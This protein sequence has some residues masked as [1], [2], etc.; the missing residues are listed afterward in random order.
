M[1]NFFLFHLVVIFLVFLSIRFWETKAS[2]LFDI[3]AAVGEGASMGWRFLWWREGMHEL[4]QRGLGIF[5]LGLG[6]FRYYVYAAYSHSL[7]FSF[8][9]S[10]MDE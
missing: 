9:L 7:Y 3:A 1:R 8:P 5:G 10:S 4:M 6:G 2:R